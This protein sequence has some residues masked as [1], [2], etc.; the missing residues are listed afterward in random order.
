M[1]YPDRI[2]DFAFCPYPCY[3]YLADLADPEDWGPDNRILLN[4]IDFTYRRAAYLQER[5]DEEGRGK[6]FIVSDAISPA[7][8]R[9][10]SRR[11]SRRYTHCSSPTIAQVPSH[12]SSR[13]SLSRATWRCQRLTSSLPAFITPITPQTSFTISTCGFVRI[14]IIFWAM[15]TTWLASRNNFVARETS[16][17]CAGPLRA[18]LRR[19]S[20]ARLRT[21]PLRYRS[22]TTGASSC[23]CHFALRVTSRSSR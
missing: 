4:Y 6:S 12:G 18:P 2:V 17:C 11:A 23:F 5:V 20:A 7:S 22:T 10:Y 15:R 16:A 21:T 13:A 19:P 8:I 1:V 3:Q 9:G 14:S